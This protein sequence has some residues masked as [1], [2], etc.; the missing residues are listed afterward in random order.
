MDDREIARRAVDL[1]TRGR[2]YRMLDI[3]AYQAWS[4]RKLDEGVSDA[5]VA[6]LDATSMWL[7]PE[8]VAKVTD[9]EFDDLL[10]DL[11]REIGE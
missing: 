1:Q 6:H 3:P 7:L 10:A 2:D 9:A 4:Q 8:D 5:L 11:E